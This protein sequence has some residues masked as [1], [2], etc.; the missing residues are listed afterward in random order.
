[1]ARHRVDRERRRHGVGV[2]APRR[3]DVH[4]RH[5]VRRRGGRRE[6]RARAG[7]G[8]GVV[9]RLPRPGEDRERRGR[10]RPHGPPGAE[11]A[12][13]RAAG[14]ALAGLG[15]DGV[16]EG[17]GAQP[18]GELRVAGRH[19]PVRRRRVGA[20]GLGDPRPERRLHLPAGGRRGH[21]PPVPR[22]DRVA[23]HPRL[24]EPLR[25]AP[26]RRGPGHRQRAARHDQVGRVRRRDRGA[27]RPAPRRRQPDRAQLGQGA[28][29]RRARPR[30]VHPLGERR[31]RHPEPVLRDRRAL[32][33][34]AVQRRA[35]RPEP[36]R[37]VHRRHRRRGRLSSTRPAG[38]SG[39]PTATA[40]RTA[41][42]S[43]S[44]SR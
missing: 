16:A 23:V 5:A 29:R 27:G 44:T 3:R 37:P 7:P 8:H 32:V 34:A 36:A 39:T 20:P 31:R 18:G 35:A 2:H 21:G 15:G 9:D 43:P 22:L 12:R 33:L 38:P 30:G 1:M 13:Q 42:A 6:H 14:V 10:G 41:S 11:H 24:R 40:S 28:V 26:V 19:R 4:R 17:P 25:R